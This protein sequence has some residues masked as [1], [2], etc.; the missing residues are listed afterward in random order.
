MGLEPFRKAEY[1]GRK[2]HLTDA[3]WRERLSEEQYKILRERATEPPFSG[4]YL[5]LTEEGTFLCAGCALPLFS[6]ED[7][8]ESG[9]GW[10]SFTKPLEP[11]NLS[12]RRDTSHSMDRVEIL[13]SR[14]G[15]HLGHVFE[16]GPAP[17]ELRYC[18]NSK[19]LDFEEEMES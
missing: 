8:F 11:E 5:E 4:S 12:Y 15:S 14:C 1:R 10:P 2:W 7:K 3:E 18:V 9:S 16:D 19:A 6:S 17:T 13:C